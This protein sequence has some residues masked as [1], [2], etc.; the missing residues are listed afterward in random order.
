M[1]PTRI[2]MGEIDHVPGLT[3]SGLP[4]TDRLALLEESD[5]EAAPFRERRQPFLLYG[6]GSVCPFF[7]AVADGKEWIVLR[8]FN[9]AIPRSSSC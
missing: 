9:V 8:L 1:V 4:S 5:Q 6:Y 2:R 7:Q 3:R